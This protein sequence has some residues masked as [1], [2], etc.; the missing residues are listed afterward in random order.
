[1]YSSYCSIWILALIFQ[2]SLLSSQR[3][4]ENTEKSG[5]IDYRSI[6]YLTIIVL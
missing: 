4:E 6:L 3:V 1:M 5:I 2:I